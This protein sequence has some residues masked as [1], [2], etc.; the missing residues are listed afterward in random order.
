MPTDRPLQTGW[1][2]DDRYRW[3]GSRGG[4][5]WRIHGPARRPIYDFA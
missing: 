3:A 1:G 2:R 5:D 4:I